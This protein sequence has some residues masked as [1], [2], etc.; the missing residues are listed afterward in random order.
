MTKVLISDSLSSRAVEIFKNRGLEVDVKTG[1]SS[2]DL[3]NCIHDYNGLVVRSATKVT[4]EVLASAKNLKVVGR[5]GIGVDNID[6]EAA[7][8]NGVVVMN[9]PFGNATSKKQKTTNSYL[10]SARYKNNRQSCTYFFLLL[11]PTTL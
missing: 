9:T 1:M 11:A 6:I 8:A 2:E 4:A 10:S 5:A 3:I 7:S